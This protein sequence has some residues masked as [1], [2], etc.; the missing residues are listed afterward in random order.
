MQ[1]PKCSFEPRGN[2]LSQPCPECNHVWF[3]SG[4]FVQM[5][6]DDLPER[7]KVVLDIGCGQKGVIGQHYW[8]NH[9]IEKATHA[10]D[11]QLRTSPQSGNP[12]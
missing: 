10:T 5:L 4:E 2:L 3:D 12:S 8:E 1:C 9:G 7:P 11:T 6:A